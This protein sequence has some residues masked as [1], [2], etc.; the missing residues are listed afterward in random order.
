MSAASTR[1]RPSEGPPTTASPRDVAGEQRPAVRRPH[2][3][4][5]DDDRL[6]LATLSEGLRQAGYEVSTASSGKDA[7]DA[8]S[9]IPFDLG[10][11]DVRMPGMDGVELARHLREG[12]HIPFIFLSAYGD[13]ELVRRA[14]DHG[15]LGYLIKPV[16]V[17]QIVPAIESALVRA[18][19]IAALREAEERLT[20]ALS[21][22]Q[23]TRTAVGV[24][25]ERHGMDRHAAFEALRHQARSQRRKIGEVA[26]E[27][28]SAAERLNAVLKDP[29]KG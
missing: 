18:R 22:E 12:T 13:L 20:T 5:V 19:E 6:I 28:I 15:A 4:L 24:L 14:A 10:I 25:I 8:A 1:D 16:D 3:L 7:I 11:L 27:I 26:D 29:Q 9:R 23:R 21:I 2:L 17:P